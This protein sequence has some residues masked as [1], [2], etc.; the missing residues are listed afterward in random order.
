M[1]KDPQP[2]SGKYGPHTFF[3]GHAC[4]AF[5]SLLLLNAINASL[6]QGWTGGVHSYFWMTKDPRPGSGKYSPHTF[7]IGQAC[8]AFFSL[9]LLNAIDASFTRGRARV[10]YACL[11]MTKDPQPGRGKYGS[12]TFCSRHA[13]TAFISLLY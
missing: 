7:F 3:S 10:V 11:E 13:C 1:T 12:H 5:F 4:T 6:T 9:L 2:G 8:T